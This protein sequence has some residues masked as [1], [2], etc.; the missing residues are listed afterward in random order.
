MTVSR[1]KRRF[2]LIVF[3]ISTFA[4]GMTEYVVTGLMTQFASDLN[5]D[6]ATTGL[7]LSIYDFLGL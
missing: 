5:V 4:I 1:T 7:L 2:I 6:L 3:M